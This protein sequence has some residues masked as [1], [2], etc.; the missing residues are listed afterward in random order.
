[1]M[2][3]INKFEVAFPAGATAQQKMALLGVTI[4]IDFEYFEKK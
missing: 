3:N 1:M 2:A 4:L